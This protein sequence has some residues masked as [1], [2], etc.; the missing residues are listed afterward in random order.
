MPF[1]LKPEYRT[2]L[3]YAAKCITGCAALFLVNSFVHAD[4]SWVLISML[5]VLSPDG[6]EAIPLTMVRIKAN[7]V[8]SAVSIAFL[9]ISPTVSIAICAAIAVTIIACHIFNLMAGSRVALAG[10]VII[11]LHPQGAHLWSTALERVFSV[12]L[13]CAIGLLLTFVF[14]RDVAWNYH[15]KLLGDRHS[16]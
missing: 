1:S 5:L 15:I 2:I 3:L 7:L 13:G 12:I 4:I 9:A 8:A 6:N 11:L 10:V 14:H 16:E